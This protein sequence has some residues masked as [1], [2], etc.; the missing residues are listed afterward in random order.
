MLPAEWLSNMET[1]KASEYRRL[2]DL[3]EVPANITDF[4]DFYESRR[5]RL[6]NKL[7]ELLGTKMDA[8]IDT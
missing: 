3:G 5:D 8:D 1:G 6:L 4:N 7:E 2:Y